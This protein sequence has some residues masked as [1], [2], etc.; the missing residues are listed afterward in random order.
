MTL[1]AIKN[2]HAE[3]FVSYPFLDWRFQTGFDEKLIPYT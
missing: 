2:C 3:L 1:G